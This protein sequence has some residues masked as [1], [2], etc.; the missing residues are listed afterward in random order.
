MG[1]Q[2]PNTGVLFRNA[3]KKTEKHPDYTGEIDI[4]GRPYRVSGWINEGKAGKP[5]FMSLKVSPAD[6]KP[7]AATSASMAAQA[8][9][10][11]DTAPF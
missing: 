9:N 6:T 11:G 7:A 3:E 10:Y 5:K 1:K 8:T 2:K 4:E